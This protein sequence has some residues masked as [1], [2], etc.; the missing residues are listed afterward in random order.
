MILSIQKSPAYHRTFS[1]K[2]YDSGYNP[3][4]NP[5]LQARNGNDELLGINNKRS[6]LFCVHYNEFSIG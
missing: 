3:A 6:T 1:F 2:H 4:L 5:R